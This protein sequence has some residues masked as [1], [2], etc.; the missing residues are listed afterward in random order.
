MIMNLWKIFKIFTPVKTVL[1]SATVCMQTVY[2]YLILSF[3]HKEG[4]H[5]ANMLPGSVTR[6]EPLAESVPNKPWGP[7]KYY[8]WNH[9]LQLMVYTYY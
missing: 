2:A 8:F 4:Q 9:P 5:E 1:N 6:H 3:V 7:E